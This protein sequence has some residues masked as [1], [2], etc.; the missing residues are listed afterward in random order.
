MLKMAPV[1]RSEREQLLR[2]IE[3]YWRSGLA[4]SLFTN[5]PLV[6]NKRFDDR[7]GLPVSGQILCSYPAVAPCARG[8]LS[9]GPNCKRQAASTVAKL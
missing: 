8:G 6:G 4:R 9:R 1:L 2:A 7:R 5:D 3:D